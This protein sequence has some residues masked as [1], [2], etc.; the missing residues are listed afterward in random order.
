[1]E[2]RMMRGKEVALAERAGRGPWEMQRV[3]EE[4]EEELVVGMMHRVFHLCFHA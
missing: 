4:E 2:E 3:Q 1:M